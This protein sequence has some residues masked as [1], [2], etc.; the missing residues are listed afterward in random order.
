MANKVFEVSLIIY[1]DSDEVDPKTRYLAS[2]PIDW[3]WKEI[4][5]PVVGYK[6]SI[7]KS[8]TLLTQYDWRNINE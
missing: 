7:C 6:Y 3:D 5:K 2:D 1:M 8:A 4:L